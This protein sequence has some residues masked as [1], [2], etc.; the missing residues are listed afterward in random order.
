[1]SEEVKTFEQKIRRL[2]AI[3]QALEKGDV[4]L[5]DSL[6]M[7]QEGTA[8]I[9]SCTQE[10]DQAEQKVQQIVRGPAGTLTAVPFETTEEV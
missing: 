4:Q 1:M 2:E 9:T 3:V 5:A 6:K 10:L 7:F 8:L